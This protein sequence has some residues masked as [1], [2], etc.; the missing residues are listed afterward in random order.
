MAYCTHTDMK[1]WRDTEI[2][3]SVQGENDEQR[4]QPDFMM[5]WTDI[6]SSIH[7]K[8]SY[9]KYFYGEIFFLYMYTV[10]GI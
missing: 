8:M 7:F 1:L 2:M 4:T 10:F 9:Q 6:A 3:R 5:G